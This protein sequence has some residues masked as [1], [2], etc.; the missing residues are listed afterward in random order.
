VWSRRPDAGADLAMMLRITLMT[1]TTKPGLTG[2][3]TYKPLKPLRRECRLYRLNLWFCRVHFFLHADHGCSLH[4]AFPAP[5]FDEGRVT[6]IRSDAHRAATTCMA[7]CIP[8][9]GGRLDIP[10][11]SGSNPARKSK[12]HQAV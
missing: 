2:E 5:S 9:L 10:A 8:Y 11:A 3:T 12:R 7:V 4:P 6:S 1:V